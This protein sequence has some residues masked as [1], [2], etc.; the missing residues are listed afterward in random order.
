MAVPH[1]VRER[2]LTECQA[3]CIRATAL[4]LLLAAPVWGGVLLLALALR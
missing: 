4:G 3:S 2:Q 1:W